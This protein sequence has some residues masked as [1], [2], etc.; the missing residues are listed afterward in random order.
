MF[1]PSNYSPINGDD[2]HNFNCYSYLVIIKNALINIDTEI[3][4]GVLFFF[5]Q[6][7][8]ISQH[9]IPNRSYGKI[10]TDIQKGLDNFFTEN[11][12]SSELDCFLPF[13]YLN[14]SRALDKTYN[15]IKPLLIF[16]PQCFEELSLAINSALIYGYQT[17]DTYTSP[18][19]YSS[20][21]YWFFRN[22]N[23]SGNSSTPQTKGDQLSLITDFLS[24]DYKPQYDTSIPVIINY[25]YQNFT[26]GLPTQIRMG[27]Q[28]QRSN[29]IPHVS[30]TF[31]KWLHHQ[32]KNHPDKKI[33][34]IYFNNLGRDRHDTEGAK[35]KVLTEQLEALNNLQRIA[36]ITF[37]AD[38]GYFRHKHVF[39]QT[40]FLDKST[41]RQNILN[42][43][44]GIKSE[45][46]IH[47]FF[48]PQKIKDI[49]FDGY[50]EKNEWLR[51]IAISFEK[52]GLNLYQEDD[53]LS[54]EQFQAFLFH[55]IKFEITNLIIQRVRPATF[56]ISCKDGI[57]RAASASL[58]YNLLAS[59]QTSFP[60][61]E[62]EFERDLHAP[63]TM[64]KGR[65]MNGHKDRLWSAIN[66]YV[67]T[68]F[69]Q[70]D[71]TCPWLIKWRDINAPSQ[72]F[73]EIYQS[74][75]DIILKNTPNDLPYLNNT[76]SHFAYNGQI[77]A[78]ISIVHK[79]FYF[80]M[81]Y[82]LRDLLI[83]QDKTLIMDGIKEFISSYPESL[84][85]NKAFT[86][87][88]EPIVSSFEKN[89]LLTSSS[90]KFS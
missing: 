17:K 12:N 30:P 64:V 46:E 89:Y 33:A 77:F 38:K 7:T 47:D 65:A 9:Y 56:N 35:E 43:L 6:L 41:I 19:I 55:L 31:I 68:N 52:M 60:M 21:T 44:M 72:R 13:V 20:I 42:M 26:P 80:H 36:V 82:K 5:E 45:N 69:L 3:H 4:P 58:Y 88:W 49:L 29:S 24:A 53:N 16:Y 66:L 28:G 2:L 10:Y 85:K 48:I 25:K 73:N 15:F 39:D 51:L 71:R 11:P 74:K 79:K 84:T 75:K 63:A 59:L 83:S 37:P 78:E 86:N 40:P 61:S 87:I 67:N 23:P 90:F 8:G 62:Y 57:D 32:S 22:G 27:T 81:L 1:D 50:D 14:D 76:I 18:G 54:Y 34:H 70:L